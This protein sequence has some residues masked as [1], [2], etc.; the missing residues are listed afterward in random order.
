LG[1]PQE[2]RPLEPG[3]TVEEV[4]REGWRRERERESGGISEK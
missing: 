1:N 3:K 2:G 4:N